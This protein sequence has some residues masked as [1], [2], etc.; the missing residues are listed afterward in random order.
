MPSKLSSNSRQTLV[1]CFPVH[2]RRP[3]SRPK[4]SPKISPN[5]HTPQ[6]NLFVAL[7]PPAANIFTPT[8][9][10]DFAYLPKV[11]ATMPKIS[12]KITSIS[13]PEV[14]MRFFHTIAQSPRFITHTP[15]VPWNISETNYASFSNSPL[16][17]SQP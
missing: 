8:N 17:Q 15:H 9:T 13:S 12:P 3:S 11:T 10:P 5:A 7:Q 2:L 4:I 1:K 14:I 6:T 16:L